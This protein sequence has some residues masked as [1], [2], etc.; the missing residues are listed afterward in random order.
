MREN[1][2][3]HSPGTVGAGQAAAG[4]RNRVVTSLLILPILLLDITSALSQVLACRPSL[5]TKA[6]REVRPAAS[7]PLPWKW[8]ATIVVD[9]TFCASHSGNFEIDFI[10]V[11]ENSPDLQF[12][13]TF[14]WTQNLLDISMELSPDEAIAEF[15]IGFIAPCVCHEVGELLTEPLEK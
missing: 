6:V 4:I 8:H 2:S 14:R 10:R 13:Q 15:R 5:S 1:Q 9:S 12:T 3:K 7:Q 11:K